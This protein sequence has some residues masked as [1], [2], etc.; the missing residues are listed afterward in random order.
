MKGVRITGEQ[1]PVVAL[2][3]AYVIDHAESLAAMS[4]AWLHGKRLGDWHEQHMLMHLCEMKRAY[5][6]R[7][8]IFPITYPKVN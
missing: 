2:G 3:M 5:D 1:A 4:F 7:Q 8:R 6:I